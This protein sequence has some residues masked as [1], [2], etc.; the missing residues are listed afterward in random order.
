M[1][2][3]VLHMITTGLKVKKTST[4]IRIHNVTL[5]N[6]FMGPVYITNRTVK[7]WKMTFLP[8]VLYTESRSSI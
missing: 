2:Q 3:Q 1:L 6:A 7:D 5:R 8:P 4:E